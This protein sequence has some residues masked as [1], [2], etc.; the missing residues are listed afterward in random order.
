MRTLL[1]LA[2][3]LVAG[4]S[5]P[6][7]SAEITTGPLAPFREVK[8]KDSGQT[9]KEPQN[10]PAA[11]HPYNVNVRERTAEELAEMEKESALKGG[12][13]KD[14]EDRYTSEGKYHCLITEYELD[15]VVMLFARGLF[16]SEG[17]KELLTKLDAACLKYRPRRLRVFVVF[18]DKEMKS[19]NEIDPKER[20]VQDAKFKEMIADA[21]K[22]V[23]ELKLKNVTLTIGAENMGKT[24]KRPAVLTKYELT[25]DALTAVLYRAL[26]IRSS[27]KLKA[28]ELS[29]KDAPAIDALMKDVEK[30]L[31]PK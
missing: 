12:K 25:D 27:H 2:G 20:K 17:F 5:V 13:D 18:L 28:D 29:K 10:V 14:K 9:R 21:K 23:D 7:R 16:D 30:H 22:L 24:D 6:M 26:R 15:P 31:V 8:D 3:L 1:L 11:F 4:L 19:F